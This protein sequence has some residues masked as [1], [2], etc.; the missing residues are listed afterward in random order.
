MQQLFSNNAVTT[1]TAAVTSTALTLPVASTVGFPVPGANQYFLV[2][3]Q[4][5]ANVEVLQ[6]I[7]TSSNSLTISANGRGWEGST[8]AA[9]P[10]GAACEVRVTAGTLASFDKYF[11]PGTTVDALVA[12][13]NSYESGYN[14]LNSLDPEG[15]TIAV[16]Q[17]SS[18]SWGILNYT[19]QG[20]DS[21]A[22]ASSSSVIST[23]AASQAG[24]PTTP[25]TNQYL[26]QIMSGAYSG[27]IRGITSVAG[28][29][30][31]LS[32]PLPST[33]S[34]SFQVNVYRSVQDLLRTFAQPA[35]GNNFA[36]NQ[37]FADIT[38]N[39]VG[40]FSNP[41]N[42]PAATQ[43]GQLVNLA[44]AQAAFELNGSQGGTFLSPSSNTTLTVAQSGQRILPTQACTIT[45]PSANTAS[46]AFFEV[47]GVSTGT[48]NVVGTIRM[49]DGSVVSNYA[50]PTSSSAV[51]SMFSDG[52]RWRARTFGSEVVITATQDNQSVNLG[53]LRRI[54]PNLLFNSSGEFGTVGWSGNNWV[55]SSSQGFNDGAY[56]S[57]S[58]NSGTSTLTSAGFTFY[59]TQL[60]WVTLSGQLA[61]PVSNSNL[62]VSVNAYNGTVNLGSVTSLSQSP[63]NG[64]GYFAA[65]GQVPSNATSLQVT[66]NVTGASSGTSVGVARIKVEAGNSATPYNMDA[67]I[68]SIANFP[69]AVGQGVA[70]NHAVTLGQ[71]SSYLTPAGTI[72]DYGGTSA[73]QGYLACDG[74]A[75]SR[76]T[77]AYLFSV[78]G[79]SWGS[80]DGSTTFNLPNLSRRVTIGSGGSVVSAIGNVVGNYGGEEAHTLSQGEMPTH[81]HS[82]VDNGHNH[83]FVDPGHNHYVNDPGHAHGAYDSGHA[84]LMP[85]GG[86]GQAGNDNGSGSFS[87]GPNQYGTYPSNN[88]AMLNTNVAQANVIVQGAGTGIYLSAS[89]TGGYNQASGTGVSLNSAGGSAAHNNMQPSAVVLKCIKY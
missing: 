38:V 86:R 32:S 54:N 76:S 78:L 6:V 88:G 64:W 70:S 53:Q 24:V 50:I 22:T 14:C 36:G 34:G 55:G 63:G 2:T 26:V 82:I 19:I 80:G 17:N 1:L 72:I 60:S 65:S 71:I 28:N 16:L 12:P 49:P 4:S 13:V 47:Y 31:T 69:L 39:G 11:Y 46:G 23:T 61:N 35:I 87:S 73:P 48:V 89:G 42:A 81:N 59:G 66:L 62:V 85:P 77:Y 57:C 84:H 79:T 45:L 44:Q 58:A 37:T 67:D 18:A 3:L 74:S 43:G 56:F 52:N 10:S 15:T 29:S 8:A 5:G 83:T 40:T 75:V 20:Q 25:L 27:Y 51:I 9:F 41:V 33:P 21:A 7:G 30:V 68:S